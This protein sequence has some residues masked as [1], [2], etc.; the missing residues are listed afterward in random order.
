M[1]ARSDEE[2][3]VQ[4]ERLLRLVREGTA[5]QEQIDWLVE[6]KFLQGPKPQRPK[7]HSVKAPKGK[8]VRLPRRPGIE[9][10]YRYR[11]MTATP[12]PQA[13]GTGVSRRKGRRR[14]T[15]RGV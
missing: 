14:K 2:F 12:F 7:L 15:T 6:H 11:M 5:T 13:K 1:T 8:R 4:K 10:V 9:V 3:Y